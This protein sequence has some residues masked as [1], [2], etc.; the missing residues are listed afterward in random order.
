MKHPYSLLFLVGMKKTTG[1][2]RSAMLG[3]ERVIS[4][5]PVE[6]VHALDFFKIPLIVISKNIGNKYILY[7]S[8]NI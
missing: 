7:Y 3:Y 2:K 1:V 5:P 4:F 6:G 8:K